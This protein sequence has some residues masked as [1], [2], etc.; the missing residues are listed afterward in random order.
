MTT[1]Y[2]TEDATY[3]ARSASI[4]ATIFAREAIRARRDGRPADAL[5]WETLSASARATG[6]R[7]SEDVR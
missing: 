6:R 4:R 7:A 1:S 3:M 5:R 2:T